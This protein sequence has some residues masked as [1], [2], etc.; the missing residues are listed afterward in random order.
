[1]KKAI[2]GLSALTLVVL[3]AAFT[4]AKVQKKETKNV[5]SSFVMPDSI[6]AIVNHSCFMCHNSNSHGDGKDK[7]SF[8][9]L[10]TMKGPDLVAHIQKVAHVLLKDKMPPKK[11][12]AK[13]PDKA[14]TPQQKAELLKWVKTETD[15]LLSGK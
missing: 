5:T 15:K 11:F 3:L 13:H 12:L 7:I 10:S 1:M 4:P 2:V 6:K 8:D 14:L 9:Q